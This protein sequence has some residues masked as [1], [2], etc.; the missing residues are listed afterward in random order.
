MESEAD[1]ATRSGSRGVAVDCKAML[2]V[3]Q[4]RKHRVNIT[5]ISE[6]EWFGQNVYDIDGY[7]LF[8]S[9]HSIPGRGQG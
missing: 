4:L 8:H 1:I 5:G 7:T 3:D 6:T 9:G 2:M